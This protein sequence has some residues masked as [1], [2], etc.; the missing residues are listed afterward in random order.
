MTIVQS[1]NY[2]SPLGIKAIAGSL[3]LIMFLSISQVLTAQTIN[4]LTIEE[5]TKKAKADNK[6]IFVDAY[7]DWCHW[8]KVMDKNTFSNYE[9]ID[10][11]S[12]NYYAVKLDAES[13][14]EVRFDGKT[15]TKR[16]LALREFG[17]TGYPSIVM[18][19]PDMSFQ[20]KAGYRDPSAFKKML[21]VF[22]AEKTKKK[23][24]KRGANKKPTKR[25]SN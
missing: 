6:P 15:M 14:A 3:F 7:T 1:K 13:Q 11:V 25:G 10:Y 19:A 23:P 17:V 4:W 9:I 12:E 2:R 16:S 5:A 18:I 8:C 24:S 22:K 21:E 20:V